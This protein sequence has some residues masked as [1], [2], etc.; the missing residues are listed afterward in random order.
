[1]ESA[2]AVQSF[3]DGLRNGSDE[4]NLL[5]VWMI[6]ASRIRWEKLD[7]YFQNLKQEVMLVREKGYENTQYAFIKV[8]IS[9]R[10]VMKLP[11]LADEYSQE[12]SFLSEKN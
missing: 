8:S 5:S 7:D 1:M 12:E 4:L 2:Q 9:L 10:F 11:A 3:I 6:K